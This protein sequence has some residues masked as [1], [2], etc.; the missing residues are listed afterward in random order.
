MCLGTRRMIVVIF[1]AKVRGLDEEYSKVAARMRD[2]ALNEFGC[3]EFHS[4]MEDRN[5]VALSYWTSEENIRAWKSHPE[6]I[7]AQVRGKEV[8]YESYSVQTASI[9]REYSAST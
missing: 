3:L 4:V 1:R 2:L 7:A 8:W 9:T 6:H 5:E